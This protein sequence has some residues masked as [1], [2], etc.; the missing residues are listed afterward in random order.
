[1]SKRHA[2]IAG[3]LIAV[4]WLFHPGR[5]HATTFARDAIAPADAVVVG[6]VVRATSRWE[7]GRIVTDVELTTTDAIG[8]APGGTVRFQ[9]PGGS[10]D[11]IAMSVIGVPHL[12]VGSEQ[13]V[14]LRRRATGLRLASLDDSVWPVTRDRGG[15]ARV[16]LRDGEVVPVTTALARLRPRV[17][18]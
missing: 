5:P 4:L 17:R 13:V 10:V 18:P 2:P 16:T 8:V 12:A 15:A 14:A 11:G 9:V 3:A 6:R 1:M 7:R